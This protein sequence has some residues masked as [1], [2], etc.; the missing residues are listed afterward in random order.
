MGETT[1]YTMSLIKRPCKG[2]PKYKFPYLFEVQ[3][4]SEADGIR[5]MGKDSKSMFNVCLIGKKTEM[6]LSRIGFVIS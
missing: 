5:L 4:F 6:F 2:F 1:A 3:R